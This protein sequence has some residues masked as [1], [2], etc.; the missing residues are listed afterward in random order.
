M[1]YS[2][3]TFLRYEAFMN[4]CIYVFIE[5]DKDERFFN[6]LIRPILGQRYATVVL[7]QYA[8]RSKD[9]VNKALKNVRDRK[10]DCLFLKDIDTCPC[11]TARKQNLL[12]IYKTR[13]DLSWAVV[14]V[15]EI[16]S[17]YLAGLDDESR[18]ELGISVNRHRHTDDL[19][20]ELFEN[21]MPPRF[22]SIVDFME[23]ILNRFRINTAKGR[24]R[25]FGY[26]MDK[27]EARSEEA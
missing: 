4:E 6:A 2:F 15:R 1:S 22:D 21:L 11:I 27:V 7:W 12:T 13:I 20:K 9:D 5:G 26:L 18:Q 19:T 24:N 8:Q 10:A 23:E 3:K 17:W 14:V 25:S 16:E